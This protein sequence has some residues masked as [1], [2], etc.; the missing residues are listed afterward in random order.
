M[1]EFHFPYDGGEV[2]V[3]D[4]SPIHSE[5]F[6]HL[7]VPQGRVESML[8]AM[9][10]VSPFFP[11]KYGPEFEVGDY[12]QSSINAVPDR[13]GLGPRLLEFIVNNRASLGFFLNNFYSTN[14]T[15]DGTPVTIAGKAL[16][17]KMVRLEKAKFIPEK[18]RFQLIWQ[19]QEM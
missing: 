7:A 19:Q 16:W 9:W 13:Q 6:I 17:E 5:V 3:Y 14:A 2:V 1:P 15:E 11:P 4:D 18:G 8:K 10:Q 12:Y